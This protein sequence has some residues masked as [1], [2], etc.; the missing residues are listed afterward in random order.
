MATNP[1]QTRNETSLETILNEDLVRTLFQPIVSF[2]NS[3][4]RTY[5]VEALTRGPINSDYES[6]LNL[7]NA[8]EDRNKLYD[9]DQ[10][11]RKMAIK[12][13]AKQFEDRMLFLNLDPNVIYDDSFREG[14]TLEY[15][16]EAKPG[17]GKSR[18]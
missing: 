18:L 1:I 8:A 5:A 7:F 2:T 9:L 14:N 10:V 11:A 17:S 16:R 6:A 3:E 12:R 15:L 4:P 13:F